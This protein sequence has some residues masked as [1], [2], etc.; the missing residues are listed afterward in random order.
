MVIGHVS[1]S[2][3]PFY[4]PRQ[5][6]PPIQDIFLA[7]STQLCDEIALQ[8]TKA[9]D[10]VVEL[11]KRLTDVDANCSSQLATVQK[12]DMVKTLEL[13]MARTQKV[14]QEIQLAELRKDLGHNNGNEDVN[15]TDAVKKLN[16]LV[17][18]GFGNDQNTA[19]KMMQQYSDILLNMMQQK[20]QNTNTW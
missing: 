1:A 19:V 17:A 10:N 4:P 18:K 13:S 6:N 20:L 14:I 12:T 2:F 8:L 11:Y 15:Q 16:D 7:V 9:A 3:A 5:L